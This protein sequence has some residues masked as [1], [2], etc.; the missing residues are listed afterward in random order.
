MK[1]IHQYWVYIVSNKVRSVLYIG[2]TNDL[3]RRYNEHKSGCVKGFTQ[4][5]RCCDLL[6]FEE[7][8]NID[9]AIAREKEL[10]GWKRCKK[11]NLIGTVN[12]QWIN[13]AED[14]GW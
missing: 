2:V 9:E 6:Y 4:Q 7:Y 14:M 10:K 11:E 13:L 8:N 1:N 3:Y 12:P 5:Y